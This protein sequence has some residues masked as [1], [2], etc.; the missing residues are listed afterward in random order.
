MP[1][2]I[3]IPPENINEMRNLFCSGASIPELMLKYGLSRNKVTA[4]LQNALGE[5][6]TTYAQKIIAGCAV[7]SADKRRGRKQN[8]T[9]KWNAKIADANRGK[10]RL[11]ETKAKISEASRTRFE[12]GTWSKEKHIE[13]MKKAVQTKRKNGYFQFHSQRHSE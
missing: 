2:K 1:T 10:K 3:V 7:K 4:T 13:A 8:R 6:Y 9:P 5:E 11:E 12:R